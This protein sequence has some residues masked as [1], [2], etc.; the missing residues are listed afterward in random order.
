MPS[1][2]IQ[3]R[4]YVVGFASGALDTEAW[5]DGWTG[6]LVFAAVVAPPFTA[7]PS[8]T[9]SEM[10]ERAESLLSSRRPNM[11]LMRDVIVGFLGLSRASPLGTAPPFTPPCVGGGSAKL[12]SGCECSDEVVETEGTGEAMGLDEVDW[13]LLL[14]GAAMVP[15][16]IVAGAG[17][18][19]NR[20][21]VFEKCS[22]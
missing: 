13:G 9:F 11:P 16:L 5:R 12:P 17:K 22:L 19:D 8:G 1:S 21:K 3:K 15:Q 4:L 14:V 7:L 20:R 6:R 18:G 2:L 10:V